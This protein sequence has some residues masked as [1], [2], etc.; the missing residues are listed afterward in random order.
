MSEVIHLVDR[1]KPE[2]LGSFSIY[3]QPDGQI[4]ARMVYMA[5]YAIEARE[6]I[7][8]RFNAAAAWLRDGATSLEVQGKEFQE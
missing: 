8:E 7:A 3:R 4:T 1:R 6:T 5:P 2:L